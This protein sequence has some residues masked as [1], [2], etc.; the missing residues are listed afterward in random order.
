MDHIIIQCIHCNE[1]I[2]IYIKD[3]NCKIFR[4]GVYKNTLQ[5]I[6]PHL[7]KKNCELLISKDLIFGC[8][9]PFKLIENDKN[10]YKPVLCDYI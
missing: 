9:K 5:N 2:F 8:G 6:E 10:E 1:F 7:D 3:I 4:H